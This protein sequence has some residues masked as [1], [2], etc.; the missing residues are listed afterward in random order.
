MLHAK[1]QNPCTGDSDQIKATREFSQFKPVRPVQ[2]ALHPFCGVFEP[3]ASTNMQM[4]MGSASNSKEEA[5]D[6][7][8]EAKGEG[9]MARAEASARP[10]AATETRE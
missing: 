4:H 6:G 1:V 2:G 9:A 3:S 5:G 8:G 7:A 10:R